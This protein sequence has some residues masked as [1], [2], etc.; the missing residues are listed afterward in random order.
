MKRCPRCGAFQEP[1]RGPG[2]LATCTGCATPFWILDWAEEGR[3]LAPA[4]TRPPS[5][6]A[7]L[8]L[9]LGVLAAQGLLAVAVAA[10]LLGLP[11]FGLG[12]LLNLW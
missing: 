9:H 11:A 7:V 4:E 12:R 5:A 6:A 2:D 1:N 10:V 8:G 3:P